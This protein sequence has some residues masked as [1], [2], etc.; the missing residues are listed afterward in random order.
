MRVD[1]CLYIIMAGGRSMELT[2]KTLTH[3]DKEIWLTLS[4]IYHEAFPHGAKPEWVLRQMVNKGN[5]YLLAGFHGNEAIAM[6]IAGLSGTVQNRRLILDYMAVRRDLRGQGLGKQF[7]NLIRDSAI[8]EQGIKS[9]LIEAEAADT[10]DNAERI[11]FWEHNG[12]IATSYTQRYAWLSL[13]YRAMLLP[14]DPSVR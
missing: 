5:A 14:L 13:P 1:T 8:H 10:P 3:W 7:F 9:I 11:R 6:G 12:F 4:P 2:F